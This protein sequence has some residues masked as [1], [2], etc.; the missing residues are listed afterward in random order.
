MW[1]DTLFLLGMDQMSQETDGVMSTSLKSLQVQ[2]IALFE[3]VGGGKAVKLLDSLS[4][5][6]TE[7]QQRI[8]EMFCKVL[9]KITK[10]T[11]RTVDKNEE[12]VNT[13]EEQ[14]YQDIMLS[15]QGI[16][17]RPKTAKLSLVRN[18]DKSEKIIDLAAKRAQRNAPPILRPIA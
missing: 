16:D 14:I 5:F 12:F 10:E 1:S 4:E 15:M 3:G 6:T 2:L 18:D 7:E 11:P 17:V 8:I 13:L 9:Q